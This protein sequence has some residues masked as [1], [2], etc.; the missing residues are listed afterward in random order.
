M[1]MIGLVALGVVLGA[2][3]TEFLRA[4]NP[5][6]FSKIEDQAKRF[7]DGLG[8]VMPDDKKEDEQELL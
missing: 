8:L 2:A 6:I 5:R 7:V 1:Q 3:G 4:K